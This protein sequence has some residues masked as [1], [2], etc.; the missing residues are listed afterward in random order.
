MEFKSQELWDR[1]ETGLV[2][3]RSE[4]P[5]QQV[6]ENRKK[7]AKVLFL[8][9]QALDNS[10]FSRITAADTSKQA[11]DILK[12]E[13][14]GDEK[15]IKVKLQTLR[16]DFE[17]LS[18]REKE[19]VEDYLSRVSA[20]V[21][22]MK[23]YSDEINNITVVSKVL[24]SL[25]SKFYYIAVVIEE[26]KGLSTYSF[27]ELTGTLLSHEDRLNRSTE[28]T[29][30]KAFQVKGELQSKGKVDSTSWKWPDNTTS[31]GQG[32]GGYRGRGR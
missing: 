24:R 30:E 31:R 19:S 25:T 13:Y 17:L 10:I 15:I 21:N 16:R 18:M 9:Q 6:R 1:I 20:L 11:W 8:I 14:L 3:D 12:Q 23:S 26:T 32:R 29:E 27:D 4:P 22:L 2:D 28:K 7:D 5:T